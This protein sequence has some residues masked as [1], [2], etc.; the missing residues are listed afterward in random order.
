MPTPPC[1]RRM[2]RSSNT[3]RTRPLPLCTRRVVPEAVAMP[4]AS[5]P[6]CWSTVRPSCS[7]GATPVVP[8]MPMMPHMEVCPV[9]GWSWYGRTQASGVRAHHAVDLGLFLD[10]RL[11]PLRFRAADHRPGLDPGQHATIGVDGVGER[12]EAERAHAV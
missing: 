2:L 10:L 9:A 5:W 12:R 8:T 6:R 11:Q 7:A 3:S 1:S 4:A